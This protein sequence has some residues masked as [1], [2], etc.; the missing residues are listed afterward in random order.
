MAVTGYPMHTVILTED[1]ATTSEE[2]EQA[3]LNYF[4][5]NFLAIVSLER[6][7][8]KSGEVVTQIIS[9]EYGFLR[10]KD[11]IPLEGTSELNEREIL[12]QFTTEV[13]HSDIVIVL[14]TTNVFQSLI[15]DNWEEV[16]DAA[17]ARSVWCIGTGRTAL[18][19]IDF[20]RLEEKGCDIVQYQRVGVAR[21]NNETRDEL[22]ELIN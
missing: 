8:S 1:A 12:N 19:E 18:S 6:E 22:T 14:L 3:A 17:K 10:G 16:A 5:G 13:S 9:E 4:K 7:L 2:K 20:H 11:R 15:L 21:I